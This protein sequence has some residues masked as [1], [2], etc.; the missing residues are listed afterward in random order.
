MAMWK[1]LLPA[2]AAAIS[3]MGCMADNSKL[4]D[5]FQ[6]IKGEKWSWHDPHSFTFTITEKDYVYDLV[7][8]LRI[9]GSYNYSNIWL[10]YTLEGPGI[11]TKE[12]FQIPLSDNTG[13]WLGKGMSNLISYEQ[14]MK[15]NLR[16]QPGKYTVKFSQ[17]M[18]DE[19]LA[20]VSDIGLKVI[21]IS[22]VY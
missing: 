14:L 21:K 2:V 17:N 6:E 9:T 22:K 8:G 7:C 15:P 18:R 3:M 20:A 12:Q 11:Q 19:Q 13:K 1:P 4:L 10:V 16:L 5:E